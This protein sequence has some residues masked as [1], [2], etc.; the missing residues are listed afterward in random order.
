MQ[1]AIDS[2]IWGAMTL[3]ISSI[4]LYFSSSIMKCL[5]TESTWSWNYAQKGHYPC[6]FLKG[7]RK[8]ISLTSKLA[9]RNYLLNSVLSEVKRP[10]VGSCGF[11]F[12]S[13]VLGV[14]CGL[15]MSNI[16][17]FSSFTVFIEWPE[18]HNGKIFFSCTGLFYSSTLQKISSIII[19]SVPP[20]SYTIVCSYSS[21]LGM[22]S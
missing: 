13:S 18:I 9:L 12:S 8:M 15:M 21:F 20:S 7:L 1:T 2:L 10:K 14:S 6:S 17:C 22:R 19:E 4:V 5:Q 3:K 11:F 16:F